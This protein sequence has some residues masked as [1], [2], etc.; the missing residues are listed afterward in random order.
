MRRFIIAPDSFKGSMSAREI[1]DILGSAVENI[2]PDADI[3]KIPMSDGGEGM[4]DAY[5]GILGGEKKYLT[6]TGPKGQSVGAAYGILPDG[7]A[8]TEMAECA[9]LPLMGGE[10]DPLHA[11]TYDVGELLIAL[12]EAGIKKVLMGIG[13]SATNDCGVGMAAALG[14][15]FEDETGAEVAPYACNIGRI[16]HIRKP[17]TMQQLN[18]TVACDVDNPLC[19]ERGASAV[20]GPQKGLKKEQIGPLDEDIRSFAA[21]IKRELG[22]DVLDV[23]GAGAAGGLGAAL[24]AFCGAKLTPGIEMLLDA[25]DMDNL[26]KN[27]ELVIT[28]EGRIDFQSASGKVPVGVSRRAKRAKVPCIAICGCTGEGA[29]AVLDEGICAFYA[30][31]DGTKSFEEIVKSCRDDLRVTAA[32]VLPGHIK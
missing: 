13:G 14:Y 22:V 2:V 32:Q 29:E 8:I 7:S 1:C 10:L 18:I 31:T 28:G 20:F 19:G 23:P 17:E 15:V 11:T 30:C 12:S 21:L 4:V 27:T 25:A 26:L 6:V 5:L 24:M 9:G 3:I 16:R